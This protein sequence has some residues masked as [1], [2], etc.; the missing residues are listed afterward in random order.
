MIAGSLEKLDSPLTYSHAKAY[1][2]NTDINK[3]GCVS[4]DKK[5]ADFLAKKYR[6]LSYVSIEEM[7]DELKPSLVSVCTSDETHSAVITQLLQAKNR[8]RVIF[9]EKPICLTPEEL[10]LIESLQDDIQIIVNHSR[11]YDLSHKKIKDLLQSNTLGKL[12][13]GHIYYY[14]GWQHI[15]V[16]IIDILYYWFN[17]LKLKDISYCCESKRNN[18]PVLNATLCANDALLSLE[19]VSEEYYQLI[20]FNL[21]FETGQIKIN[22]FGREIVIARKTINDENESV[23]DDKKTLTGMQNP[24]V[25]SINLIVKFLKMNNDSILKD[26]NLQS[27]KK[28]MNLLWEGKAQ[29]DNQL[30]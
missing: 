1:S 22:D 28:T 20:E 5:D 9:V 19:G 24:I 12:V 3:I 21:L 4:L 11:R 26:V 8:P 13:K 30:K 15:G 2:L 25:A 23:L 16:H 7:L 17:T 14:G 10:S 29:Y 18:D 27:A 6:G